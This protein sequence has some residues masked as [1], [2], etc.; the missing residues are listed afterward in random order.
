MYARTSGVRARVIVYTIE[1]MTPLSPGDTVQCRDLI[2]STR[3][4][5]E[6]YLGRKRH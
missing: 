4:Y 2:K 6:Y 3:L 1:R 5:P